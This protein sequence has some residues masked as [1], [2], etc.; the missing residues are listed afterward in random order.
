MVGVARGRALAGS[1]L[2][3]QADDPRNAAIFAQNRDRPLPD[4]LAEARAVHRQLL[5]ALEPLADEDFR[6]PRRFRQMPDTWIP[7]QVFAANSYNHYR[8]HL[9]AL[10]AWLDANRSGSEPNIVLTGSEQRGGN[11]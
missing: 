5:D 4:I 8:D 3:G 6:D 7:W 10:Q 9:P 1:D 11:L 2:W